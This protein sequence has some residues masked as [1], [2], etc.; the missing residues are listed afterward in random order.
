MLA[1]LFISERFGTHLE[2]MG[3]STVLPTYFRT[4]TEKSADNRLIVTRF[5]RCEKSI[6]GK[7]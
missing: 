5:N 6:S 1:F 7:E 2:E 3:R 4:K